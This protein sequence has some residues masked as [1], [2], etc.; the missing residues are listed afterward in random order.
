MGKDDDRLEGELEKTAARPLLMTA[1]EENAE[2]QRALAT[3]TAEEIAEEDGAEKIFKKLDERFRRR[4]RLVGTYGE[5]IGLRGA[6]RLV[7]SGKTRGFRFAL[8][9][10]PSELVAI[11]AHKGYAV[12]EA[13]AGLHY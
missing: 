2:A 5:E 12:Y 6:R 4:V 1:I 8:V 3:L 7:R 9:G 11:H 13:R 10:E